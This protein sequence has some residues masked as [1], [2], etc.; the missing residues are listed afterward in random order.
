MGAILNPSSVTLPPP[1][2]IGAPARYSRWRLMQ[3]ESVLA[4]ADS[5]KRFIIQGAPTGFGKSLAYVSQAILTDARCAI[6]TST[7]ALQS[8][9]LSDFAESGLIEI[10]G[11]NSYECV[12]GIPTGKFGDVRREGYRADRGLPMMCDEAPCQAGAFCPKREGG[13]SY[14]DAYRKSTMAG[15]RL[16]VTNY[17]YWM[18]IHKFGEGL[19]VFDLLVLDEAHNAVDE[20][21]GFVGTELRPGEVERVLAGS[22]LA[23]GADQADW[24]SWAG[25][26]RV[27]AA[28]AIDTIRASIK[29]SE[30]TGGERTGERLSYGALRRA[31]DLK[32]LQHKLDTIAGMSGDWIID[33]TEDNRGRPTTRFEPVWPG[34]YAE[35][36]LFRG[37]PKVVMVSATVR[38]ETAQKLNIDP[39]NVD[40]K[41]YPSSIPVANRPI[42]FTPAAHMNRNSAGA[43]KREWSTRMDQIIARRLDRKGIIHTVSYSRAREVY[44]GSEYKEMLLIHDST[45]TQ[46]AIER[47]KKSTKPLVLVSPVLDT[48]LDFLYE[49]A[50]YQ[51]IA[52]VPFPVTVDKIVKARMER[53]KGYRDYVT[54]IKL[55]Q[56]VGRI[57]RADDDRGET[58]IV[59]SDFGWWFNKVRH[60]CPRWFV[61]AV[62]Y[63][64][65]L[66]IPLPK[67]V[68]RSVGGAGVPR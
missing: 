28:H 14:Y 65:V 52:K 45:N 24:K 29:E 20:L 25:Y 23:P 58:L 62:R 54:I 10:R 34:E 67:L 31:R 30:R 12:E 8:Q 32:K 3:A 64:Q 55:V 50:E 37:I 44:A 38:P 49:L 59:D 13:C 27:E 48:G 39:A 6:L 33:Y 66:G 35:S 17:A 15:S 1:N 36:V 9:L 26:W 57:C 11:L 43:G 46:E 40:F 68:P 16:I 61:E 18:S 4:A 19:G 2:L 53:D 21:G 41:E 22:A 7:K 47:F 63:E 42:V 5:P 51:I 56:M 60:H